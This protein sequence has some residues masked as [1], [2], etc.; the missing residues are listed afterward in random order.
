MKSISKML[1]ILLLCSFSWM[2]AQ[3]FDVFEGIISERFSSQDFPI[4][5]QS[6]SATIV[7]DANENAGV[8]HAAKDLQCDIQKV[9]GIQPEL[10]NTSTSQKVELIIGTL[11]KSAYIDQLLRSGA[12]KMSF[13][14]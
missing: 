3:S 14:H 10:S 9:T 4:V 1:Q 13:R 7:V 8:Q 5:S 6:V 11:G 2:A 12:L